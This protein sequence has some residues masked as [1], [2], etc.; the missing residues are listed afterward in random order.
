M[1]AKN[2]RRVC[3]GKEMEYEWTRYRVVWLNEVFVIFKNSA[4]VGDVL[5]FKHYG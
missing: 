2:L 1:Y 5:D 3:V 4:W